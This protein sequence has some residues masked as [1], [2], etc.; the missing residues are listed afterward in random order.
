[1]AINRQAAI[2]IFL[3]TFAGVLWGAM[4]TAV[5]FLLKVSPG[6]NPLDMVAL[7]QICAG[8]IFVLAAMCV[9]PK[10]MLSVFHD[11]RLFIDVVIGGILIFT[12]HYCFFGAIFYSNAG[13]GAVFLTLVPLMAAVWL[14]F[15]KHQQIGPLEIVCFIF[16]VLGV[17]LI[18]T[19]GDWGTLQFSPNA[20][21]FGLASAVIATAYSIQP[22]RAI[23]KVGVVPVVAWGMLAGGICGFFVGNP[24]SMEV[25][26]NLTTISLMG[27]IVL[28]GTV[29]AFWI[30]MEGLRAT[31][32]VIAGLLNCMEP[33]SAFLFSIVLLGDR[34]G[35]WQLMGILC[36]LFNVCL[37]ALAKVRK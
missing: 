22:L 3:I 18:V 10:Q 28:F 24:F 30:Y 4:G 35:T 14:S 5:Q 33:L 37:L 36:V 31:S 1:M 6:F 11:F 26:W 25:T 34:F 12:T 19:D 20:I 29:T 13:T 7:R 2:G 15:I 32:P 16:A 27:F 21:F 9:R 8:G 17:Y 23:G